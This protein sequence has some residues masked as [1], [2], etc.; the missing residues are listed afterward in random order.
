LHD[1]DLVPPGS[2]ST[3]RQRIIDEVKTPL[4]DPGLVVPMVTT[5][6]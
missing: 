1:D 2:R 3:E 5:N 4:A 6:L